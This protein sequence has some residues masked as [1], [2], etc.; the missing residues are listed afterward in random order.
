[1]IPVAVVAAMLAAIIIAVMIVA[2]I[3][4]AM[5]VIPIAVLIPVGDIAKTERNGGA[6]MIAAVVGR[7]DGNARGIG[8]AGGRECRAGQRQR[9]RCT[10]QEHTHVGFLH[11][12]QLRRTRATR[13]R[14]ED[15]AI[16]QFDPK[17]SE[18]TQLGE[19]GAMH[20]VLNWDAAGRILHPLCRHRVGIGSESN[21]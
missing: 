18:S 16:A 3:V 13:Q 1:M 11:C 17:G 6:G 4:P 8:R 9:D 2:P 7:A 10:C 21:F 15:I 5:A 12:C 14:L 20:P 19:F